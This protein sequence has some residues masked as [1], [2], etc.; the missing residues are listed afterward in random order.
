VFGSH[1]LARG[2][3]QVQTISAIGT[4]ICL[5]SVSLDSVDGFQNFATAFLLPSAHHELDFPPVVPDALSLFVTR[6]CSMG[7]GREV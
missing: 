5:F 1:I 2:M 3:E 6:P 7:S 4:M